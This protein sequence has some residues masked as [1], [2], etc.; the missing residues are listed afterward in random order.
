MPS[1]TLEQRLAVREKPPG[2][3][4]MRQRWSKLLFLHWKVDP[5]M[6]RAKLP[7]GLHLDLHKGEAW[8]GIVPFFMDRARPSLLPPVPGISWFMELN[9]RTYVHDDAGVPGVWF[10]SLDCNQPLA[11]EFARSRFHLPYEHA[12][13]SSGQADRHLDYSCRRDGRNETSRF[14]YEPAREGAAAEPGSLEFFLAERYLLYSADPRNRIHTGR[15]HH[16]PYLLEPA[17]CTEWSTLPAD[18]DELPLPDR[19]ADSALV[20]KTVDV[21]VYPLKRATSPPA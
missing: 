13:M 5:D 10:F 7:P 6:L 1:P 21:S 20:A 9:V 17:D 15:V 18:W 3:P 8:L 16:A 12:E 11:V 14:V 4:V 19:P 2:F